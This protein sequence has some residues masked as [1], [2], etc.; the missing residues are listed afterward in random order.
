MFCD[1]R[2]LKGK[3]SEYYGISSYLCSDSQVFIK[4][5]M[6]NSSHLGESS[7][8]FQVRSSDGAQ[9]V[10]SRGHAAGGPRVPGKLPRE[11]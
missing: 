10:H 2:V 3:R 11:C 6:S 9:I 4:G 5:S 7:G 1:H 8:N